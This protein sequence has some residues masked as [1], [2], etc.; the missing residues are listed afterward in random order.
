MDH[1]ASK[2]LS[3][4]TMPYRFCLLANLQCFYTLR[5]SQ[6]S[7]LQYFDSHIPTFF[8][9]SLRLFSFCVYSR[10]K[11]I[12]WTFLNNLWSFRNYFTYE[13]LKVLIPQKPYPNSYC[14]KEK[15]L[16]KSQLWAIISSFTGRKCNH[17]AS[18][19][20]QG[21]SS[22]SLWKQLEAPRQMSFP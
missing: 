16:T 14:G 9:S 8:Q 11:L 1:P 2:F 22:E 12:S 19:L 15:S 17:I 10:N 18:V 21:L 3:S 13:F 5:V 20:L 7:G 4:L 6:R